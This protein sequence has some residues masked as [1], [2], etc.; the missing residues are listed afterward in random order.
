MQHDKKY[1]KYK[2]SF[3]RKTWKKIDMSVNSSGP[4][5][6]SSDSLFLSLS[7]S[8]SLSLAL[9][10]Y[11]PFLSPGSWSPRLGVGKRQLIFFTSLLDLLLTGL[12]LGF[13]LGGRRDSGA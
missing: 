3:I 1:E 4:S 13:E 5:F 12:H 11:L 2:R 7:L 10:G 9:S 8:L 6:P